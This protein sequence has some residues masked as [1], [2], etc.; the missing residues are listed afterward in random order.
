MKYIKINNTLTKHTKFKEI[1]LGKKILFKV[2]I[3][4][5]VIDR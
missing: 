5:L 4:Q 2:H 1:F 3:K